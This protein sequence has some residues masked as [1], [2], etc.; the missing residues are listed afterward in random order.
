MIV[1]VPLVAPAPIAMLASVPWSPSSEVSRVTVSRTLTLPDRAR[2]SRAVTVALAPS[3]TGF[4][5]TDSDTAGG[6]GGAPPT[7]TATV[8]ALR[9]SY[10]ASALRTAWDT[11]APPASTPVTVTACARCQLLG[12][13]RSA[14][15]TVALP[16]APLLGVTVT[17]PVG[18]VASHT[19]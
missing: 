18:F 1:P 2:D 17:S 9:P 16:G 11:V 8:P 7:V 5:E 19:R 4:G 12:V 6:G 14:P 10:F 15:L 3:V 13:K